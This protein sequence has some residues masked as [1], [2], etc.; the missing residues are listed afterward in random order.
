MTEPESDSVASP[1]AESAAGEVDDDLVTAADVETLNRVVVDR[2]AAFAR[3]G[4]VALVV[5]G[6]IG[7]AAWAWL[8]Y[9][10]QDQITGPLTYGEGGGPGPS[11]ADRLD[12]A[13]GQTVVLVLSVAVIGLGLLVRLVAEYT[14]VRVGVSLTGYEEGD[15]FPPE[16]DE[17]ES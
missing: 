10:F 11:L 8:M 2:A 17:E 13:A 12:A 4:G 3:F 15:R 16:S 7:L 14:R 6:A 9:R 1:A 5:V